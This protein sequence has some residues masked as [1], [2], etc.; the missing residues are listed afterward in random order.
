MLVARLLFSFGSAGT[1]SSSVHRRQ[2][3]RTHLMLS[4]HP[5]PQ[6][7]SA[8]GSS[9]IMRPWHACRRQ[10][11]YGSN[12]G[13][14]TFFGESFLCGDGH[15]RGASRRLPAAQQSASAMRLSSSILGRAT[16]AFFYQRGSAWWDLWKFHSR[17]LRISRSW[18]S[19]LIKLR[20]TPRQSA[21]SK[22]LLGPGTLNLISG[23]KKWGQLIE[24]RP[25]I[26]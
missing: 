15:G 23:L 5:L 21:P 7:I 16:G 13:G 18:H 11:F 22:A 19:G 25:A 17:L 3:Q 24:L 26:C 14:G 20:W 10:E 2:R 6:S 8:R 9:E 12:I 4:E 1:W